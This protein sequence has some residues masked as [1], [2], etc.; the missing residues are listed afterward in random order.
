MTTKRHSATEKSAMPADGR[1]LNGT[2]TKGS[3]TTSGMDVGSQVNVGPMKPVGSKTLEGS[4]AGDHRAPANKADI[5]AAFK[6][7]SSPR[8]ETTETEL[9]GS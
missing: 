5:T 9:A 2:G 8:G 3:T 1:R 4:Y 7:Q 6:N